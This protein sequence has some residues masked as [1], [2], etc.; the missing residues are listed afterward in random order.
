MSGTTRRINLALQGG[1]AHGAFT[2]GVLDRLLEDGRLEF[3]G[4]SGTSAGAMNGAALVYG[5]VTGG[6]DAAREALDRLW[7]NVARQS[8]LSPFQPSWIERLTGTPNL[9]FA[10]GYAAFDTLVRLYSPYV[11]NPFGWNPLRDVLRGVIDFDVLREAQST[12]L[13]VGATDVRL[14]K[15][16][17]FS[18]AEIS[19]EALL[20]SA[21]LPFLFQAVEIGGSH[22]WDGGYLGNPTIYP[23][24]HSCSA[25]D[26]VV[27]QINPIRRDAV[28][29]TP[30]QIVDRMNEVSFNAAFL[31]EARALEMINRLLDGGHLQPGESGLRPMYLHLVGAE[32]EMQDLTVSSKLNADRAFLLNLRERGRRAA[33]LWL[34]ETWDGLGR[35]STFVVESM[36]C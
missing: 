36:F 7:D 30:T 32:D 19:A 18:G 16:K 29:I 23:L 28:P 10:P 1:G 24:I 21:C 26:I 17:V 33:D 20:A 4:V 31:R 27:V 9:E 3:D 14:G 2:W 6:R 35:R 15:L 5:L 34:E 25:Q 12:R 11:F 22:Y 13:Y 8:L